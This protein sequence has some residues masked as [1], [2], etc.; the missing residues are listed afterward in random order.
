MRIRTV[1]RVVLSMV[2]LAMLVAAC[3][4]RGPLYIPDDQPKQ[5]DHDQKQKS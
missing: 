4:Q 5:S 3:G 2:L 1:S